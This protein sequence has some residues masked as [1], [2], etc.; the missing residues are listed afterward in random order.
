MV[1]FTTTLVLLY[2]G[3]L[4]L[5]SVMACT[6]CGHSNDDHQ[7]VTS[8]LFYCKQCKVLE[9]H[10]AFSP[11]DAKNPSKSEEPVADVYNSFRKH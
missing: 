5:V 10:V 1:G 6:V 11:E 4:H 7:Y 3:E 2:M 9:S 8:S